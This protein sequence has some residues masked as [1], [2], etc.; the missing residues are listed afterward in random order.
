[1]Y[2]NC[3]SYFSLRYGTLDI[4][5]LI[6]EAKEKGVDML[7]LTDI[8]NTSA[9]F[10]FMHACRK[11][12]IKPIVGIDF[13]NG[14]QQQFIGI[15]RNKAGF[16]EL[17]A[18]LSQHLWNKSTIPTQAPTFENA[19]V[20]YPFDRNISFS[21]K[22]NEY[23]GVKYSDLHQ[24]VL[25]P[26]AYP[27][28]KL[29]ILH[30]V[31]FRGK[32]D[33]NTHRLL[34][35]I[36]NNSLLSKLPSTQLADVDEVMLK[37]EEL[38][39]RFW[40][41]PHLLK[42]TQRLL[43][44]CGFNFE[45][46]KSRNKKTYTG[47]KSTDAE[48]LKVEAIKGLKYRYGDHYSEAMPRLLN[49][50]KVIDELEFNAY[51]LINW[52]LVKYARSKGYYYVGRG[53]GA[54][55]IVAYC[56]QITDVDPI[57]LDLYFE[58][59]INTYRKNSPPDFDIDFSWKDRDD[60]I[61]YV[62]DKYGVEHTALLATHNSFRKKQAIRE[63]GKVFGLPKN[64]IDSLANGGKHA[65]TSDHLS[66]LISTYSAILD[67]FPNHLSIHASGIIITE[68]PLHYYTATELPPKDFP[69]THFDMVTAEDMGFC[70]F[71][72]LSQRGLGHIKDALSI[73][74]QNRQT[75]ID[76]HDVEKFKHDKKV[77][78]LIKNGKTIGCFYVESPAMR[79]LL[80]KLR[81]QD[82]KTLVAA[83][84][85][86]RPGV[87]K[88]GMMREY[89]KRFHQPDS[90]E[91]IHPDIGELLKETY[92]VMVY[93]EDVIKVAHNIAGFT[94]EESDVLRR[95]M[96]KTFRSK[97][98]GEYWKIADKF[99]NNCLKRGYAL[100][101]AKEL[102][103][104]IESFAS[105]AFSKA[106]SASYAV[107]SYQSLYLKA[108][109]P[110]EFL[111]G[112]INNFGGF[113]NTELYV[114]EARMYGARIH[115]PCVNT[116]QYLTTIQ[117]KDI[118]LGFIHLKELEEKIAQR[119]AI[120]RQK[121]RYSSLEDF[122]GRIGLSTEQL[123]ILIKVGA[124][125]YTGYNKKELM[126]QAH[127]KIGKKQEAKQSYDLFE[128]PTKPL[129]L[130]E[131]TYLPHEDAFDEIEF[132]G[133]PL[134]SPFELLK[135]TPES[136]IGAKDLHH[137]LH[138]TISITGYLVNVKNTNTSKGDKMNFATFIDKEGY[139]FDSTHFPKIANAY[140]FSGK[141]IYQL[142]GTVVKEFDFYSIEVTHME[143]LDIMEDP[144]YN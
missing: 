98:G 86:I 114:H 1:M 53:S 27:E 34:R 60:I 105:F 21:L 39:K 127:L 24:L 79:M 118:Y 130:P 113:Y 77:N 138:D 97:R 33:Y 74:Y 128:V 5:K 104:Q 9:S 94:L 125:R 25:N 50:L 123:R 59:F 6:S 46:G 45:T 20:I 135:E 93:Q 133:F 55:S 107:E 87:A 32:I 48:L 58:R 99:M 76:I 80:T 16:K 85:I 8:N 73:I 2:L 142:T 132:L 137:H 47:S 141:G 26:T 28:E 119:I 43:C 65:K 36:D 44:N 67:G 83:S 22:D 71:D 89:I 38:I 117:G 13:R 54:N 139:F 106:H 15:A 30:P 69:I 4:K 91:H 103:R 70:K 100:S 116:S 72:L 68:K 111:V 120:E 3:H 140:P 96:S 11:E 112:V 31:T 56:L 90:F 18:Y 42:N 57:E 63:L 129:T 136:S 61:R 64:E 29:V 75:A 7:A 95:G 37:P 110:L 41:Y 102:W 66:R 88:S 35:A 115:A 82:Y 92:G 144:R 19:Y 17:N 131:I 49:E 122:A 51:F 143:Q 62:F 134:C 126:W 81:C 10:D 52:D 121:R 108:Y 23:I 101:V 109:Y 78:D 12:N 14:V 124:F 84:S 40:E